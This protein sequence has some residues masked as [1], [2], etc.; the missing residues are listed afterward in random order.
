MVKHFQE[1]FPATF[2]F[3]LDELRNYGIVQSEM[4]RIL[5]P[6]LIVLLGLVGFTGCAQPPSFVSLGENG[7]V[8]KKTIVKQQAGGDIMAVY[9]LEHTS[10]NA[11]RGTGNGKIIFRAPIGFAHV[12]DYIICSNNVIRSYRLSKTE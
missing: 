5:A 8:I 11:A 1:T 10:R 9:E 4:N 6:V 12:G 3:S 7:K 2:F